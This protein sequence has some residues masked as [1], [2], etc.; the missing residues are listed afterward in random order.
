MNNNKNG[1][2]LQSFVQGIFL[3][4]ALL[5]SAYK[6][7]SRVSELEQANMENAFKQIEVLNYLKEA[8][9]HIVSLPTPTPTPIPKR[10]RK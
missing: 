10:K 1:F 7:D 9:P 4:A 5:G 6:L 2:N 3:M 8:R